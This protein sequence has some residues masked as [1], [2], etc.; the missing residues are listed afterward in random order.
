MSQSK[1]QTRPGRRRPRTR[2]R[3]LG[4]SGNRPVQC[5]QS[6]DRHGHTTTAP[7]T[8]YERL[9]GNP[10][11]GSHARHRL[12]ED[13][14]VQ[15]RCEAAQHHTKGR[16]IHHPTRSKRKTNARRRTCT[17][18]DQLPGR[19]NPGRCDYLTPHAGGNAGKLCR[20]PGH[21][22]HSQGIP[23]SDPRCKKKKTEEEKL[24][25]YE[26]SAPP[27]SYTHLTLPTN[28]EV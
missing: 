9:Q 25:N 27:V 15:K 10:E 12:Y 5:S 6:Q 11:S 17:D 8:I 4:R 3:T 18:H 22:T 23:Q 26:P 7:V 21:G 19:R 28:R 24:D 1:P 16:S 13:S 14:S 2:P 20:S